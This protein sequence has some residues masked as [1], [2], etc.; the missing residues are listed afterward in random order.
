[1]SSIVYTV[2][3]TTPALD[4]NM[5]KQHL[6]VDHT[7]EDAFIR[8]LISAAAKH[9]QEYQWSQLLTATFQ[10]NEDRFGGWINRLQLRRNPVIAGSVSIIYMD[11]GGNLVTL[12]PSLY[13]VDTNSKPARLI[14]EYAQ[15][16]P[17]TRGLIDDVRITFQAGFGSDPSSIP[18]NTQLAM[19]MLIG[20]W[21]WHRECQVGFVPATIDFSTKQLLDA[22]SY[23]C[24]Y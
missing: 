17:L 5:V 2:E 18:A 22:N 3:P 7:D 11:T 14:P 16:W 9:A 13:R 8:L 19:L 12:D 6:R 10:Q 24:F 15:V 20:H 21:Y 23:R 1:M 4:L